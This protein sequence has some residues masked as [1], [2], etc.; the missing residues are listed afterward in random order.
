MD[1]KLHKNNVKFNFFNNRGGLNCGLIN[2][3]IKNIPL[4]RKKNVV[5]HTW[6]CKNIFEKSDYKTVVALNIFK[7]I[8]SLSYGKER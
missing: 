1:R 6:E 8:K 4:K 2:F 5:E 3:G 7:M